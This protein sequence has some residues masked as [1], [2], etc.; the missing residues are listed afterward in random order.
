MKKYIMILSALALIAGCTPKPVPRARDCEKEITLRQE[1]RKLWTDHT[2]WTRGYIIASLNGTFDADVAAARLLKNQDDIG[3]AIG[4]FYGAE[5][6][7]QLTALLKEHIIIATTLINAHKIHD[8]GA[9]DAANAK[10]KVNADQIANFLA[11]ANPALP[12][13]ELRA[14]MQKHLETT[15]KEVV[16]RQNKDWAG[17]AAAYD[18]V[19]EHI[20]LMADALSAGI[21]KQFPEKF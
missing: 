4:S 12:Q 3:R 17:D 1:M 9:F 14:M 7:D 21:M 6:G 5:A 2:V 10:W 18:A 11:K 15:T 19:Y 16:A 13:S 8:T 20:L